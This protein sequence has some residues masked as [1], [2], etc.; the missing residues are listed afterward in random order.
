M[1]QRRK[2]DSAA[3]AGLIFNREEHEDLKG[4]ILI[5]QTFVSFALFVVRFFFLSLLSRCVFASSR[6][7]VKK[8]IAR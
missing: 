7:C 8:E 6:L 5:F 3:T 4:S 1:S 2:G